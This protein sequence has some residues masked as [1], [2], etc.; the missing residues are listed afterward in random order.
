M[1][2]MGLLLVG[3]V[4]ATAAVACSSNTEAGVDSCESEP[5][6]TFKELLIVDEDVLADPRSQNATTGPWSFRHAV[7]NMA[8]PGTDPGEFVRS[9]FLSWGGSRTFNGFTLDL[10]GEERE[11]N[12]QRLL[13]CPWLKATPENACDADC[14]TCGSQKLDLAKAPFRLIAIS[15]RVDLR[16][17]VPGSP[18]GEGR[19]LFS[20][21]DGP[22]DSPASQPLAMVAIFEYRLPTD[23]TAKE[24]GESWHALGKFSAT[25]EPYRAAL[26][27]VTD[28]FT[29]RG[30]DPSR[31]NGSAIGQV[32]TN[33]NAFN[34]IWQLRQFELDPANGSLRLSAVRNTPGEALNNSPAL[35]DY[36]TKN[37][38]AVRAN[39][40]EMPASLRAGSADSLRYSWSVPEVDEPTRKAFA[41]GTCNGCHGSEVI[42][43]VDTA[44]HVSP[45]RKGLEKLSPFIYDPTSK[46]PDDLSVRATRVRK[47]LCGK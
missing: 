46:K 23:R 45:F 40:Y 26:Q 2:G 31:L 38:D 15:N 19:L 27:Q 18:N 39:F 11:A 4:V 24:W 22:A 17:E 28:A 36:L 32:R 13:V 3:A 20:L 12:M 47:A 29:K 35:R 41:S 16:E 1:R 6:D 5:I 34:W 9:W 7:E 42:T 21:T 14:R 10:Q 44:F 30:S 33:D 37:A 8:P 25:E 43:V